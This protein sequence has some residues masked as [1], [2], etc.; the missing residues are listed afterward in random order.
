LR[1]SREGLLESTFRAQTRSL[2]RLQLVLERC[3]PF[4][5]AIARLLDRHRA[6]DLHQREVL[7]HRAGV[8]RHPGPDLRQRLT[9]GKE[10]EPERQEQPEPDRDLVA[11]P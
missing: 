1:Q 6:I 2:A 8:E 4:L 9:H 10:R 11:E 5:D 7:R 3:G